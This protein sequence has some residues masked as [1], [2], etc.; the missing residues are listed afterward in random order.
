MDKN[1]KRT[2]FLL[3]LLFWM[4]VI[5]KE[6]W[7]VQMQYCFAKEMTIN[8]QCVSR[9]FCGLVYHHYISNAI[10]L[11]CSCRTIE[12][13][14]K[15]FFPSSF[16]NASGLNVLKIRESVQTGSEKGGSLSSALLWKIHFKPSIKLKKVERCMFLF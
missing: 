8:R 1:K 12:Y 6:E 5:S 13:W 4:K 10:R 11:W 16:P 3:N 2:P 9:L 7:I 15:L 14:H